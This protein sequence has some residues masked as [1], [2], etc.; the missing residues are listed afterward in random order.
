M[1]PIEGGGSVPYSYVY[2]V[3]VYVCM[4]AFV[5]F[6]RLSV[7]PS[8]SRWR[9]PLLCVPVI[10]VILTA[11]VNGSVNRFL[12]GC[13]PVNRYS[14]I[15][16]LCMLWTIL[17]LNYMHLTFFLLTAS[18]L[19][20]PALW[21]IKQA[22]SEVLFSRVEIDQKRIKVLFNFFFLYIY[23]SAYVIISLTFSSEIPSSKLCSCSGS[24]T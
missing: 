17:Y 5:A 2:V 4:F 1:L 10:Y 13:S 3:Y 23:A 9:F 20:G 14:N 22:V 7:Y 15:Y 11:Q 24:N 6:F 12:S 21:Y 8:R 18:E 19:P 16:R